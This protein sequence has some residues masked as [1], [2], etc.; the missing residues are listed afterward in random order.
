MAIRPP[1]GQEELDQLPARR[2]TATNDDALKD[3]PRQQLED[4]HKL[5]LHNDDALKDQPRQQV[6]L[7]K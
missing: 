2:I 5:H 6:F 4:Y 3:Q 1:M 7:V